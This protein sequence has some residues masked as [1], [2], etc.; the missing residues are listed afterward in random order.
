MIMREKLLE[1]M[2]SWAAESRWKETL[3]ELTTELLEA[4]PACPYVYLQ[5][6]TYIRLHQAPSA[7]SWTTPAPAST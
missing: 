2:S 6:K 7:K 3:Q 5:R 1:E 4:R